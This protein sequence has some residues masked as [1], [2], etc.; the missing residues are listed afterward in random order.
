MASKMR[1]KK[2]STTHPGYELGTRLG[3]KS[4][5][6]T[7]GCR[8]FLSRI[9]PFVAPPPSFPPPDGKWLEEIDLN[10]VDFDAVE[11]CPLTQVRETGPGRK[12]WPEALRGLRRVAGSKADRDS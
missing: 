8:R 6:F 12:R 11:V 1:S 7:K 10:N 9:F 3:E 4:I 5:E 2:V